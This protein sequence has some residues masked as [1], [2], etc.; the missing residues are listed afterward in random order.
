[1]LNVLH[2]YCEHIDDL[3]ISYVPNNR[4]ITVEIFDA[5]DVLHCHL[6]DVQKVIENKPPLHLYS[7]YCENHDELRVYFTEDIPSTLRLQKIK[8][9]EDVLL[10][11]DNNEKLVGLFFHNVNYRISKELST[12]DREKLKLEMKSHSLA[13]MKSFQSSRLNNNVKSS[14]YCCMIL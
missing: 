1:M 4:I 10:L 12:E 7:V 9:E 13:L 8:W 2:E 14:C 6:F 5:S 3:L 11:L